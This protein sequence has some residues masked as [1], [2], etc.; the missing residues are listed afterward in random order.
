VHFDEAVGHGVDIVER[1]RPLGMA[2]DLHALPAREIAV[3]RLAKGFD[4]GLQHRDLIREVDSF[5]TSIELP[6]FVELALELDERLLEIEEILFSMVVTC[7]YR[8]AS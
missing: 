3:D 1:V 5:V 2:G 4:P 6:H 7:G 8:L